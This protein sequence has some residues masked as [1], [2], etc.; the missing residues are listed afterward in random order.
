MCESRGYETEQQLSL[1]QNG[2]EISGAVLRNKVSDEEK[3]WDI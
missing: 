2:D 1:T 3:L